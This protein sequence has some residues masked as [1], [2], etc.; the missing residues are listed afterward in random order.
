MLPT[1]LA[2]TIHDP[3]GRLADA[4]P[5]L[6]PRLREVFAGI[7]CNISDQTHPEVVRLARDIGAIVLHPTGLAT[8]GTARRNALGL[9]LE[10]S[11]PQIIYSDFDHMCRWLERDAAELGA[12][13]ATQAEADFLIIGRSDRAFAVEPAR[14]RDTEV[15]VNRVYEMMTGRAADLMFAVRRMSRRAAELIVAQ[16]RVETLATDVDWPLLVERS[17]FSIGTVRSDAL[18][19]RTMDEYGA[20][21]DTGDADPA[22]WIARLEFAALH[23]T[24]MR[25]YLKRP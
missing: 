12:L 3:T 1:T 11:Q 24:A 5:A 19:Y 21:A 9:A 25:D 6:A 22:N 18:Y 4:I 14:L 10:Q 20:R 15:L 8:V 23:A 13:L 7:A 16:S 2:A 17:G